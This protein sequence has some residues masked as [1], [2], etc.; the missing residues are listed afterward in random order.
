MPA[1]RFFVGSGTLSSSSH[2]RIV[3]S[4]QLRAASLA[5]LPYAA[6]LRRFPSA[7]SLAPLP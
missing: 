2:R 6:S 3:P 1:E 4:H 7:A 5:P